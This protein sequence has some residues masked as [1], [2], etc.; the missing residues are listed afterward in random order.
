MVPEIIEQFSLNSLNEI[1][2]LSRN[3]C[4]KYW[5]KNEQAYSDILEKLPDVL[6]LQVVGVL[7]DVD[8]EQ[9]NEAGQGLKRIL[10][11]QHEG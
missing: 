3:L 9:G 11:K 6:V 1:G 4:K 10:V 5:N 8:A 7:P 2:Y